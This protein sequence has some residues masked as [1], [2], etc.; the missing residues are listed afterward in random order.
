MNTLRYDLPKDDS[1]NDSAQGVWGILKKDYVK[2]LLWCVVAA[3]FVS[4]AL[5]Y[6][7]YYLHSTLRIFGA[8]GFEKPI[9]PA[10]ITTLVTGIAMAAVGLGSAIVVMVISSNTERI[11]KNVEILAERQTAEYTSNFNSATSAVSGFL[12]LK[13]LVIKSI[14]DY[15]KIQEQS[16]ESSHQFFQIR[17]LLNREWVSHLCRWAG[18]GVPE[19]NQELTD[20]ICKLSLAA[21]QILSPALAME[22]KIAIFKGYDTGTKP[23]DATGNTIDAS[24]KKREFDGYI[25]I[26]LGFLNCVRGISE[27]INA[28]TGDSAE[29][30]M[31]GTPS[32][33]AFMQNEFVKIDFEA[34][35]GELNTSFGLLP[36]K[37]I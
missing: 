10:A 7:G 28:T 34:E 31:H 36:R 22:N 3:L 37:A 12:T 11:Y 17:D 5:A 16:L 25:R 23:I 24:S 30:A 19:G 29:F 9:D 26:G 6:G 33:A 20:W 32:T 1:I 8:E 15:R 35:L 18:S 14:Y 21:N 13:L 27:H 4:I 2:L